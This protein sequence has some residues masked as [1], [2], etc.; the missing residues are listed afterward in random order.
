MRSCDKCIRMAV[1][2]YAPSGEYAY[3]EQHVPRGCS[4]MLDFETDEPLLDDKG[5]ELPCCE[6]DY[7]EEGHEDV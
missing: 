7:S 2:V 1:W 6:Y 3:C 5:R 4:C